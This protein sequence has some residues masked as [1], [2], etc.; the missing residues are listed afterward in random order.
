MGT[1]WGTGNGG[2]SLDAD[3]LHVLGAPGIDVAL[4]ILEGLEGVMTPVLLEARMGR[5]TQAPNLVLHPRWFC[6]RSP[7]E[8]WGDGSMVAKGTDEG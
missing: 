4:G 5:G 2:H 6:L 3:T 8:G 7:L 1:L